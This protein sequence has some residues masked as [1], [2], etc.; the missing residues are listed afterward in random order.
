MRFF[1]I[2]GASGYIL[3]FIAYQGANSFQQLVGTQNEFSQQEKT[4]VLDLEWLYL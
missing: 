4:W 2:D 3:D 1:V